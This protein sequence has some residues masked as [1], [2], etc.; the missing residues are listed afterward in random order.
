MNRQFTRSHN[1]IIGGVAAGAAEW[2]GVDPALVRIAWALLV[3][4]TSGAAL[5]AYVVAWAIVPEAARAS[6]QHM[7]GDSSASEGEPVAA[8]ES[9]SESTDDNRTP[10]LF[11][12]GLIALGA[13][14]LVRAYLPSIDWSLIWP[15][16]LVGVGIVIL[17]GAMRRR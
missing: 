12:L 7:P 10:L 14:F 9:R 2:A 3:P 16:V 11:G 13:W 8:P 6:A 5:L 1:R 4:I 17:V 15:V